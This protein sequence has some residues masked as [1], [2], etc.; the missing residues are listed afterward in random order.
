LTFAINRH[1]KS[2][3]PRNTLAGQIA[4]IAT[5]LSLSA[6]VPEYAETIKKPSTRESTGNTEGL[7]GACR[8]PGS[9]KRSKF[10]YFRFWNAIPKF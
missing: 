9:D 2:N 8:I 7:E 3:N 5:Q 1:V 10:D 6:A 4:F